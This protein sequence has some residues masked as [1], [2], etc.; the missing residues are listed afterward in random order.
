[1]NYIL[2]S[3]DNWHDVHTLAKF[4]RHMD[5]QRASSKMTSNM[6]MLIG[7]YEGKLE[8]SFIIGDDDYFMHV[9]KSGYVD[10]Q[11]EIIGVYNDQVYTHSRDKLPLKF[12][13]EMKEI[14][15]GDFPNFSYRPDMGTWWR[16]THG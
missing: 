13:G 6:K 7:G 8:L 12:L 15:V 9:H 10:N 3:I 5:T 4:L 11:K 14:T 1:M 16:A 2:F